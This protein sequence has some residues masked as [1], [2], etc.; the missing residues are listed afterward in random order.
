MQ[1]GIL[2]MRPYIGTLP[3]QIVLHVVGSV[4]RNFLG[5]MLGSAMNSGT[6]VGN[7]ELSE[8]LLDPGLSYLC[9]PLHENLLSSLHVCIYNTP[10]CMSRL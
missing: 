6:R 5:S 3:T 9:K 8:N 10:F 4:E 2:K 7:V 1:R